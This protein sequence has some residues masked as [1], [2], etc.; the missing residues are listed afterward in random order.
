MDKR[1][2]APVHSRVCAGLRLA[3]LILCGAPLVLMLGTGILGSVVSG[4]PRMDVLLPA[5]LLF[6]TLPGMILLAVAAVRQRVHARPAVA[7]PIT[8]VAALALC[9]GLAL[10]PGFPAE[11]LF[12]LLLGLLALYDL[13]AAAACLL[14]WLSARHLRRTAPQHRKDAP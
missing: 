5:E 13:C 10:W 6:L 4:Q 7:L 1:Q 12:P 2:N 9:Q 14:G 11:S 3:G 8:A